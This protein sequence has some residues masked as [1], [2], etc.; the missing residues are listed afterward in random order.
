MSG[1]QSRQGWLF[2]NGRT[3][4]CVCAALGIISLVYS[5]IKMNNKGQRSK[6]IQRKENNRIIQQNSSHRFA[7]LSLVNCICALNLSG[8]SFLAYNRSKARLA[9]NR[10]AYQCPGQSNAKDTI[11]THILQLMRYEAYTVVHLDSRD[12]ETT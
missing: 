3:S 1:C 5:S 12:N 9:R 8:W 11:A 2:R 7:K 6:N 4:L 10:M